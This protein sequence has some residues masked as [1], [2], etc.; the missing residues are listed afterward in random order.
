MTLVSPRR[1]RQLALA[2][3]GLL[4]TISV[5]GANAATGADRTLLDAGFVVDGL[6][7]EGMFESMAD[8]MAET[9]QPD[10]PGALTAG[11]EDAPDPPVEEMAAAAVTPAY[12]GGEVERNVRDLYAYLHGRTDE[13]D[14]SMDLVPVKRAFAGEVE[15]WVADLEPGEIDDRMGRLAANQSAFAAARQEFKAAQLQRIQE[16]TDEEYSREELERLY[17]ENR[18]RI[19]AEAVNRL[20]TRVAESDRPAP[21]QAALVDYGTVGVDALVSA[22]ASYEQFTPAEA[23]A[24][25]DVAAAVATVV[26]NRLDAEVDDELDLTAGLDD[27]ARRTLSTARTGVSLVGLLALVLPVAAIV[28]AGLLGYVSRRRSNALWRVGGIVAAVGLLT[29]VATMVLADVLPG[30]VGLDGGDAPET[31][32]AALGVVSRS[33]GAI[34]TQSLAVFVLG[35]VLVVAGVAIRRELVPVEDEPNAADETATAD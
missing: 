32:T 23:D 9:L 28:L 25:E 29:A 10:D 26:R 27:S 31:V 7:A 18:D 15:A 30:F 16:R 35:L 11:L 22:D 5:V 6:E 8:D 17:D 13:L 14:L 34:G 24:R 21:L 1:R 2:T 4:L 3:L 19:R 33:L 20:E 12:V